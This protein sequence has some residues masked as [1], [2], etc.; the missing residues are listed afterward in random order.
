MGR[1]RAARTAVHP[2][3]HGHAIAADAAFTVAFAV[4]DRQPRDFGIAVT[5]RHNR[6]DGAYLGALG[7]GSQSR[8][9]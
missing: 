4:S 6:H 5:N 7:I 2:F 1:R 8:R 3:A 9:R